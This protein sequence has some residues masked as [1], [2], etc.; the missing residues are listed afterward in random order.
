MQVASDAAK[1]IGV[2]DNGYNL[3]HVTT[4]CN[5]RGHQ[6]LLY[7]RIC[8]AIIGYWLVVGAAGAKDC[9]H[10]PLPEDCTKKCPVGYCSVT[11]DSKTGRCLTEPTCSS[12][13]R[14]ALNTLKAGPNSHFYLNNLSEERIRRLMMNQPKTK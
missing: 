8:L 6:M 2:F 9:T 14:R 5:V 7:A 4:T 10:P 13:M 3:R 12:T 11:V 1:T